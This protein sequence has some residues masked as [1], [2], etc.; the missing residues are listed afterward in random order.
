MH[1]S[2][3]ARA[4]L[5]A[6]IA[7]AAVQPSYGRHRLPAAFDRLSALPAL[8]ESRN[9]LLKVLLSE[10]ASEA[11]LVR[12]IESDVALTIAVLRA[13]NHL[14]ARS[15]PAVAS[16]PDAVARLSPQGVHVLARRVA[17]VDFFDRRHGW[18]SPPDHV[19]LHAV[20]V[21]TIAD[22]IARELDYAARDELAVVSLLHDIGKLVLMEAYPSYAPDAAQADPQAR[23]LAERRE[24]GVDHALVAAVLIRRWRLP[25]SIARSVERH[26]EPGDDMAAAIVELADMLAHYTTGHAVD[27]AKLGAAARRIRVDG[28]LLRSLMYD[29]VTAAPGPRSIEPCP[30]TPGQM[31]VL[32]ALAS[33]R[34][35]KQIAADLNVSVSTVRSHAH[36]LYRRLGVGDRAQAV[37]AASERGW[38]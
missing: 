4:H 28:E 30:L 31:R 35:Y 14:D 33:G 3:S 13:A 8:E 38:L 19:R 34:V 16:V 26:H 22:R 17:V 15:R 9:R 23:L 1:V 7:P 10:R 32:R 18:S 27:R 12:A 37:L 6:P 2:E 20:T 36:E 25:D 24:F 29:G 5:V 11:D 21:Q